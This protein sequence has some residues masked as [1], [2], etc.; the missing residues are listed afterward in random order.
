MPPR[1][2]WGLE[3]A[4][5][6]HSP[7]GECAIY[8]PSLSSPST[9]PPGPPSWVG[10]GLPRR[11]EDGQGP[12]LPTLWVQQPP[13]G[14]EGNLLSQY[15]GLYLKEHGTCATASFLIYP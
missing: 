12:L 15:M 8:F 9:L 14:R 2:S 11:G 7:V 5:L 1:L 10:Q 3:Q 6:A 13:A 4:T